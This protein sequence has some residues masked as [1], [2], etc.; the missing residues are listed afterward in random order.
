M[1]GMNALEFLDIFTTII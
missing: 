1:H